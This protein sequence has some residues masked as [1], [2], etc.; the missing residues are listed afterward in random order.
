MSAAAAGSNNTMVNYVVNK[1]VFS[2]KNKLR[3][4]QY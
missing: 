2:G 1:L 3:L 4:I